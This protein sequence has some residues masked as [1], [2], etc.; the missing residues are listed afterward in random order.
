MLIAALLRFSHSFAWSLIRE[1]GRTAQ[2]PGWLRGH[3][4]LHQQLVCSIH[5]VRGW[6][7]RD[8]YGIDDVVVAAATITTLG[9]FAA[10]YVALDYGAGKPWDYIDAGEDVVPFNQVCLFSQDKGDALFQ[11][12]AN[13]QRLPWPRSY[14]S[15]FHCICP[16]AASLLSFYASPKT[17]ARSCYI[18]PA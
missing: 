9:F 5:F 16:R 10:N 12:T 1:N 3:F 7:R 13:T 2:E 8:I 18:E 4:E 11:F 6:I 14:S 15:H 17:A